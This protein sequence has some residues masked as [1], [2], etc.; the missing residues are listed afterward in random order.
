MSL[1]IRW[2]V[3]WI[4]LRCFGLDSLMCLPSA[5]RLAE[6]CLI[7]DDLVYS[8]DGWLAGWLNHVYHPL[9]GQPGLTATVAV[10]F[11]EGGNL[12][13]VYQEQTRP[14]F[15][16]FLLVKARQVT[17]P[18]SIPG[19]GER[20][21]FLI[22]IPAKSCCP[23]RCSHFGNPPHAT[24]HLLQYVEHRAKPNTGLHI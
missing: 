17:R 20:L 21:H 14:P 9:A 13:A 24:Y 16:Y 1:K 8:S 10:G 18:T 12:Q 2:A 6:R 19:W 15:C 5:S 7:H 4:R 11:Q 23:E 3:I 22:E